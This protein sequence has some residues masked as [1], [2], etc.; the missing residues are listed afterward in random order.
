[1]LGSYSFAK[2]IDYT[3]N[4]SGVP[5]I[6]LWRFYRGV[7]DNDMPHSFVGSF[8]YLAPVGRGRRFLSNARGLVNQIVGGWELSGILTLRSGQPFTPTI[9]S[10]TANTGV[11][12]QRPDVIGTPIMPRDPNCWFYT[13]ANAACAALVS[14]GADAFAAPPSQVR[15]GTGG[16]N[17]L[18]ADGW[19]QLDFTVMKQFPITESKQVEFRSEFFNFLNHPT[20][21]A[22]GTNINSASGGQVASTLNAAR[23]IQFALKFRF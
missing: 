20:F 16:R 13:S 4:E 1:M 17:I 3:T 5:T 15:Y 11:G 6:S 18:R 21:S 7:C 8:D 10:D 22:P 14:N 12:S 23:I 19:K 2:C 9:S